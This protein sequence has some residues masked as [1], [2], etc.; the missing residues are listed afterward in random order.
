MIWRAVIIQYLYM[1][2]GMF[3]SYPVKTF[4][5]RRPATVG[6]LMFA[7]GGIL[8]CFSPSLLWMCILKGVIPG[9]ASFC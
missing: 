3:S 8:S 7:V 9:D 6:S 4:G 2:L 1:L 5:C